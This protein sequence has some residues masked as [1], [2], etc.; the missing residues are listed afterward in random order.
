MN[1]KNQKPRPDWKKAGMFFSLSLI[2]IGVMYVTLVIPKEKDKQE[3][4]SLTS[5][6]ENDLLS[7]V[8]N[9]D[10]DRVEE[11]DMEMDSAMLPDGF[12]KMLDLEYVVLKD[13]L[14][15]K[16]AEVL[17]EIGVQ[18]V[19]TSIY[20]NYYKND[21]S[22]II[23]NYIVTDID[24]RIVLSMSY[25]EINAEKQWSA[26]KIIDVDT[27]LCYFIEEKF[28]DSYEVYDY[29]TGERLVNDLI[30]QEDIEATE[31]IPHRDDVYGISDKDVFDI[32]SPKLFQRSELDS[33]VT[34]NW[35]VSII[36][37]DIQMVDYALSFY[38]KYMRDE[39]LHGIVNFNDSTTT[40]IQYVSGLLYVTVHEYIDGEESDAKSLFSGKVLAD[41]IVYPDNGDIEKI[42]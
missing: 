18:E 29:A 19:V 15:K 37:K 24:K 27:G 1:R 34:G 4:G 3:Q 36:D 35:R 31:V 11:N 23:E 6:A 25:S 38:Q 33:D 21:L 17:R 42:Q 14:E 32:G 12:N 7:N 9:E 16:V 8:F 20:G 5:I 41:Y 10:A 13:E 26:Y 28:R 2:I 39:E 22:A 40:C 30:S